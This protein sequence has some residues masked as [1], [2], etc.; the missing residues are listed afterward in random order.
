MQKEIKDPLIEKEVERQL[1]VL[2]FGTLEITPLE[3]FKQMLYASLRDKK[4]LRVKCGIDPT[5][6]DIHLGHMVPFKK[7]RAFQDLGHLGVVIIGDY[8]ARIGDPTGKNES[9]P[10]LTENEV[11]ENAQTYMQQVYTILNPEK[12]EVH[13]QSEWFSKVNLSDV[14][15]WMAQT[16]VAKL[17]SHDTFKKRLET[18]SALGLHEFLYPVLQGVDSVYIKADVELGGS[19]QKFNVLM[20]RDYQRHKG[21]RPQVAMLLPLIMGL[22]GK[23]KMSKTL[24]NY[25]GVGDSAFDMFGK[26]MSIPDALMADYISY[27]G[28]FTH[29]NAHA[30]IQEIKTGLVHPNE[31]KKKLASNIVSIY[32]GEVA[33]QEMRK[34]FEAVFAKGEVP[35]E[36]PEI[37]FTRGILLN[38]FLVQNGFLASKT[39]VQRM[40][41]Q[42][43]VSFM[44]GEKIND[45][46]RVLDDSFAGKVLKIGKRK[47]VRLK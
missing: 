39:E 2:Q 34:Q 8:T 44:D 38:D 35:E 11:K 47:F 27:V 33:G 3:D 28:A 19:D 10:A 6:A 21:L 14:M 16:T 4:P 20:G 37:I 25:I 18:G 13:F 7:M 31:A 32:H 42:G 45:F 43:A 9:R 26:I 36:T 23:E 24:N 29:E 1:E 46:K 30:F 41:Q 12:T 15:G 22:D 5:R 17:V 40:V